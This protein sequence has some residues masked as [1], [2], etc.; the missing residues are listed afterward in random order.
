MSIV[1]RQAARRWAS[2]AVATGALIA[3]PV[4]LAARPVASSTL[5]AGEVVAAATRSADVPHQGLVEIDASL[6][7]P[8]LPIVSDETKIL[9]GTTRVR[10]WWSTQ[11]SWRTDTITGTGEDITFSD[12]STTGGGV[13]QWSFENNT[14]TEVLSNPSIR[15]PRADDLVPPQAARRLLSWLNSSDRILPLAARRIAGFDGAGAQIVP[16]DPRGTV[17]RVD[18]WVEPRTGLPLE[19]DVYARGGENPSISTRFLDL[20]L[21]RPSP[22]VLSPTLVSTAQQ[23]STDEPDLLAR[24][25]SFGSVPLPM[26]LG[27]LARIT[28]PAA[29]GLYGVATYGSGLT[30]VVV[31]PLPDR[32]AGYVSEDTTGKGTAFTVP[33]GTGTLLTTSLISLAVVSGNGRGYIVAGTVQPTALTQAVAALLAAQQ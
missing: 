23:G 32:L 19:I 20:D 18:L 17:G 33:G 14:A 21:V 28:G 22:S 26:S 3:T 29:A 15:L 11:D 13:R 24:L 8:D 2:F 1:R 31:V 10:T 7:I 30:R 4:L 25:N 6:G 16:S 27:T 9:S 12:P 5:S